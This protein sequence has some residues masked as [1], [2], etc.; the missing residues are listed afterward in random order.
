MSS[1]LGAR[2]LPPHLLG[3][4][5]G[6][7][8]TRRY[9]AEV[10]ASALVAVTDRELIW[11][12]THR[13]EFEPRCRVLVQSPQS[14]LEIL[15]KCRQLELAGAAG[16]L[17]LPTHLVTRPGDAD[18]IPESH[19][20]LAVRPNRPEDVE[21]RLKV[22]LVSTRE[23]LRTLIG[24]CERLASPLIAQPFRNLPNL[25]VHG[26]RSANG[27]VIA[28]RCYLVARKFEGVSLT[29]EPRPFPDRLEAL[30]HAF[31]RLAGITGCYHLEFLFSPHEDQAY[32]L[33]ANVRMGGTT[34]KVLHAGFDEP[35]LLLQAYEVMPRRGSPLRDR[36]GRVVNKRVVLKHALWAATGRLTPFDHPDVSRLTHV[37]YACRDMLAARDSIVDWRD[38]SG[39]LRFQLRGLTTRS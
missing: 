21:P 27:D 5:E 18:A 19:F 13:H 8:F 36:P 38:L 3:T 10:G 39:S 25:V 9:A 6:I 37:A 12:G 35:G 34:D 11:L 26:V 28:S 16:L 14:L 22:R 20:P 7:D 23:H 17:V 24:E 32:F 33:E 4:P 15:S 2:D 1:L 31:A 29:I 30:C